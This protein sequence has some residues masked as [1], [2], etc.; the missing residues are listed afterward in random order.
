MRADV[1]DVRHSHL[2]GLAHIKLPIQMMGCDNRRSAAIVTG[3]TLIARLGAQPF[4]LHQPGNAVLAAYFA[5]IT[6]IRA[7]LAIAIHTTAFQPELLESRR[8]R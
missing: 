1:R 6:Q 4:T 2:V 7:D 3:T 8:Q 5:Q